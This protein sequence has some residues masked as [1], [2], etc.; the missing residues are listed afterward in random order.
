MVDPAMADEMSLPE[1]ALGA[2]SGARCGSSKR[3]RASKGISLAT[4]SSD[5]A[6]YLAWRRGMVAVV[7][8]SS[9]VANLELG[10]RETRWKTGAVDEGEALH[11][12]YRAAQ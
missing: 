9:T 12:F 4:T 7:E 6:A 10:R 8:W 2:D 3:E 11:A 1:W 5:G